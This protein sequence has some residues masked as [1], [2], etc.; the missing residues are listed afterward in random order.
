M[1]YRFGFGIWFI[2]LVLDFFLV[3]LLHM[4][5]VFPA[6]VLPLLIS[7][8]NGSNKWIHPRASGNRL[9]RPQR[10]GFLTLPSVRRCEEV[11]DKV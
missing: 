7:L 5:V 11:Q 6:H 3:P 9:G 4:F 10:P 2:P 1:W 8:V